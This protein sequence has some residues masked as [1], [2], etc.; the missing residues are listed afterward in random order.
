MYYCDLE[1]FKLQIKYSLFDL[2]IFMIHVEVLHS[3]FFVNQNGIFRV[4]NPLLIKMKF[5]IVIQNNF[6]IYCLLCL[7]NADRF[8]YLS[9]SLQNHIIVCFSRRTV[10]AVAKSFMNIVQLLRCFFL[11]CFTIAET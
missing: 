1:F 7:S 5:D 6:P 4:R 10:T 11:S 2:I 9:L 8:Q 3:Q